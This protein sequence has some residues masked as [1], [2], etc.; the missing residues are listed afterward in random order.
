MSGFVLTPPLDVPFTRYGK[1][2]AA[3]RR[4]I[5]L[6]SGHLEP[7]LARVAA[8]EAE[9]EAFAA[10]AEQGADLPPPPPP[11]GETTALRAFLTARD[12]D[13]R[14]VTLDEARELV[15]FLAFAGH[16]TTGT[17]MSQAL[18]LIDRHRPAWRALVEEQRRV[19]A[20][21][22]PELT[23]A[24]AADMPYADAVVRETLRLCPVVRFVWRE[25]IEE[26]A[27][28]SGEKMVRVPA[29]TQV[30]CSLA[31]PIEDIPLFTAD[32]DAFRP[33]RW[34]EEATASSADPLASPWRLIPTPSGYLP[35]GAGGRVCLGL[36]LAVAEMRAYLAVLARK[37][38][39]EV[40]WPAGSEGWDGRAT[41]T[42]FVVPGDMPVRLTLRREE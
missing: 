21:H 14:R 28:G 42:G 20:R 39:F 15:L 37:Y 19:V 4:I 5:E 25:V 33:E 11:S 32:R 6:L 3:R 24:A 41:E 29:G 34:L 13:G 40:R 16:E 18:R 31:A 1:A 12:D 22:G 7:V 8:E 36:S 10:A 35:F 26:F 2:M 30:V 17:S 27:V 9:R 38:E 23:A